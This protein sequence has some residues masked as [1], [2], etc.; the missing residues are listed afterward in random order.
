M[1]RDVPPVR[2]A[3]T[4]LLHSPF[5]HGSRIVEEYHV[6]HTRVGLKDS[7]LV[8][9]L[10]LRLKSSRLLIASFI[11]LAT[12]SALSAFIAPEAEARSRRTSRSHRVRK[13][14]RTLQ[15]TAPKNVGRL[16]QVVRDDSP[17]YSAPNKKPLYSV[18][19]KETYLVLVGQRD[20]YYAVLM[21]DGRYGWVA[22]SRVELLNYDVVTGKTGHA[23]IDFGNQ[24][25][26]D[27]FQY[28]GLR[29][30]WGGYST[31]GTDCSGFIKAIFAKN[32][33]AL[34]RV[35]RDQAKVGQ[36]V[37]TSDL[38][39]GD[40]LYFSFKGQYIDHTGLYIGNGYF[41]HN[42]INHGRVAVDLLTSPRYWSKLINCRR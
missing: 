10:M 30:V 9:L 13:T 12:F 22:Q 24:V 33:V 32:G 42:S 19:P 41:I 23:G 37:S 5:A 14:S 18:V 15:V 11:A 31:A 40:R 28:L 16:G 3:I 2:C 34:P 38:R 36:A 6:T 27:A 8:D 1:E 29:Y 17:I 26:Q 21:A 39:P 4:T 20:G 25:V 35:A 7:S